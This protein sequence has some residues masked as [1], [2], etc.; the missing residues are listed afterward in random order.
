MKKSDK[1][2]KNPPGLRRA[3]CQKL[4]RNFLNRRKWSFK[5]GVGKNKKIQDTGRGYLNLKK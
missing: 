1:I 2:K 5:R 3:F 4:N